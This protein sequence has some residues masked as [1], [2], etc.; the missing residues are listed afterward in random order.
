MGMQE[1]AP[2]L[3][4][5]SLREPGVLPRPVILTLVSPQ[6]GKCSLSSLPTCSLGTRATGLPLAEQ[7]SGVRIRLHAHPCRPHTHTSNI[8]S[9]STSKGFSEAGKINMQVGESGSPQ[10][11]ALS[12]AQLEQLSGPRRG[13]NAGGGVGP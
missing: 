8:Y 1:T 3:V 10:Y 2:T 13:K 4:L 6:A 12:I 11:Q 5:E 7:G 9:K